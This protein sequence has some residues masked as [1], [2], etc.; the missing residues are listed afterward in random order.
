[1]KVSKLQAFAPKTLALGVLLDARP[2]LSSVI[3]ELWGTMSIG[4][5]LPKIKSCLHKDLGID[6]VM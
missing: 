4:A 2:V 1:M 6:L 3:Q 5:T